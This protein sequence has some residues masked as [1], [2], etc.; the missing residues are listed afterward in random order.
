[1]AA[2]FLAALICLPNP[3]HADG[4]QRLALPDPVTTGGMPLM[5]ALAKRR[6]IRDMDT[7]PVGMQDLSNMLW[8]AWGIS[9]PD[10]RRTVPTARNRQEALVYVV[11]GKAAYRYEA[12][13]NA[14]VKV[15][16]AD[17]AVFGPAPVTL[18]YAAM[19][20]DDTG[21]MHVGSI[22]QDVGLYCASV[23]LANVVKITGR[24]ALDGKLQ[25]PSG[26]KVYA[27][28]SVGWPK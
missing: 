8:A 12:A 26:Y 22:Y 20:S 14:L 5:D 3:A 28:Q 7:K 15:S 19:A 10:G 11:M 27:V 24:D 1:M 25:L 21:G 16:D 2:F 4:E 6:S 18:A 13:D 23:G 17:A 9:R